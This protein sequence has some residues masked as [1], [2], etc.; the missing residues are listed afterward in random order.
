MGSKLSQRDWVWLIALG[1][2][3]SLPTLLHLVLP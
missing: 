1:S 3:D 2:K